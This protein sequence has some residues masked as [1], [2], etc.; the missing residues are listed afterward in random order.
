MVLGRYL[1]LTQSRYSIGEELQLL[2][3]AKASSY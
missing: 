2:V 1:Q 3:L